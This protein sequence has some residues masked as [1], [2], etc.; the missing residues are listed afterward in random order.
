MKRI[1]E[2]VIP[3]FKEFYLHFKF[4]SKSTIDNT[5]V[6]LEKTIRKKKKRKEKTI[7]TEETL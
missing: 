6:L 3:T 1:P 5:I 7:R 4:E 2:F